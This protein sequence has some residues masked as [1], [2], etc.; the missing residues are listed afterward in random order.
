MKP[1][2]LPGEEMQVTI[3]KDGKGPGASYLDDGTMIVVEGG[4]SEHKQAGGRYL[5]P[6]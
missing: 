6:A 5:S 3:V 2:V 4:Q 1:V